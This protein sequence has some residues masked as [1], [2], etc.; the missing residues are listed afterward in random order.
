MLR[1]IRD[2][3]NRDWDPIGGCPADE[4][5]SYAGKL[6]AKIGESATDDELMRYLEWAEVDHLGLGPFDS[7]RARKVI[8]ILRK[9]DRS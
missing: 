9:L 2:I 8:A 7:E 1:R 3:L 6:A 4:Y 5:D